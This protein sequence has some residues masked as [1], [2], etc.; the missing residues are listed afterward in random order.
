MSVSECSHRREIL[1]RCAPPDDGQKRADDDSSIRE[2]ADRW[3]RE[4]GRGQ[5]KRAKLVAELGV[6]SENSLDCDA[7]GACGVR[8]AAPTTPKT[9][10][11]SKAERGM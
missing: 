4:W 2:E 10:T 9:F 3:E 6:H 5:K 7:A 1:R 8:R 11:S